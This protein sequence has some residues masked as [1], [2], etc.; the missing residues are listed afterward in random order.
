MEDKFKDLFSNIG[1]FSLPD[2]NSIIPDKSMFDPNR[3]KYHS[4]EEILEEDE[5]EFERPDFSE[6]KC[7]ICNEPIE[8]GYFWYRVLLR[9]KY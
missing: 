5:E 7:K 3:K 8:D 4:P 1:N 6:W 2:M 9:I